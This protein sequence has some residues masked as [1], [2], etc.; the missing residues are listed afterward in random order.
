MG[1]PMAATLTWQGD[2]RFSASSGGHAL[3][4]DGDSGAGPSPVQALALSITGCMAM[5]VVAI[6]GKGR[7]A[8]RALDA[9][10]VGDRAELPPR[11]FITIRMTFIV[12][13][14][15]P[16]DAVERAIQLSREK[17]CSVSNSLR[18]DIEIVTGFEVR[19]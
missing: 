18:E 3:T 17:Y 2:Q 13:G 11:R 5:D 7:H 15:V 1:A 10:F 12:H 8:V 14:D 6:L 9:K 19:P 4:L 16:A